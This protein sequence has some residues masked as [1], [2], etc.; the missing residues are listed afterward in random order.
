MYISGPSPVTIFLAGLISPP[1]EEEVM[2]RELM[3]GDSVKG[4]MRSGGPV[5]HF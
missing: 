1:A 4:W 2:E 3:S 5:L